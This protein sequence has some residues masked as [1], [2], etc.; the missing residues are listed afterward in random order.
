MLQSAECG[1]AIVFVVPL[2]LVWGTN[3]RNRL[4]TVAFLYLARPQLLDDLCSRQ[5]GVLNFPGKFLVA[6]NW[7]T[8]N[9]FLK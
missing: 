8:S 3:V 4:A 7:I 9:V 5:C 1:T 2:S 6:S